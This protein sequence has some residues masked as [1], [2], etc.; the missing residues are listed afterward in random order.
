MPTGRTAGSIQNFTYNFDVIK[1][2]LSNRTDNTRNITETFGYDHL[3]RLS[4]IGSQQ[5]TVMHQIW[6]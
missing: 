4:S 2:N 6:R 1:G 3:N 5:I